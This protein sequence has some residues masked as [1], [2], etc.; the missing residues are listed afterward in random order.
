MYAI[1]PHRHQRTAALTHTHIH[2]HIYNHNNNNTD[3]MLMLFL[4]TFCHFSQI[5]FI[6][7]IRHLLWNPF[8]ISIRNEFSK[9]VERKKKEEKKPKYLPSFAIHTTNLH[10]LLQLI[11]THWLC[12]CTNALLFLRRH[13]NFRSNTTATMEL[14]MNQSYLPR[15]GRNLNETK[16]DYRNRPPTMSR[17]YILEWTAAMSWDCRNIWSVCKYR[18][19]PLQLF[20]SGCLICAKRQTAIFDQFFDQFNFSFSLFFSNLISFFFENSLLIVYRSFR[21]RGW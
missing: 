19:K 21:G 16:N 17:S 13:R 18:A 14:R 5:E 2:T 8:H 1:H 6:F 20:E 3:A 10:N 11:K 7:T 15:I 12:N 9:I 4:G